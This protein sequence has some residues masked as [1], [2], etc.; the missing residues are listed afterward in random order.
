VTACIVG[1]GAYLVW[2]HP[3]HPATDTPRKAA[4]G[5][6]QADPLRRNILFIGT[7]ARPGETA[8][9]TDTL[10]LCSIDDKNRR[11][12]LLSIPRDTKVQ[13]PDGHWGKINESMRA[14]GP[15]LTMNLV[16]NLVRQPIDDY[17]IAHF[18]GVVQVVNAM[19]G[20]TLTVPERMHY[21]TGDKEYGH[22]NLY[23]GTQHLDGVQALQFVRF[24]HDAMG[25]IGRTERQ[26]QFLEAA[27]RQLFQPGNI[28]RL[29][30]IIH[31]ALQAFDTDLTAG[32]L[33]TYAAHAHDYAN[34][35]I[36]HETLPGS[37]HDPVGPGDASYWVVNSSEAVYVAGQLFEHGVVVQSNPVQDPV[38]TAQWQPPSPSSNGTANAA[39]NG[40]TGLG[41]GT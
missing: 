18:D 34:Y 15:A 7:D 8:G 39:K 26:Q 4:V 5:R 29:P 10:I 30:Q 3:L 1:V 16:Y 14:G 11:I 41:D 12:E 21:N 33:A 27:A 28:A 24:R 37:F 19:G 25:D 31:A 17:V 35:A 40:T 6:T 2:M 38:G 23:P 13:Y 9:N 20:I 36:L 22:I 32:D